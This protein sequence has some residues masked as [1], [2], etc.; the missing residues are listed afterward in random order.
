MK[1]IGVIG[2][3]MRHA[4]LARLLCES[5]YGV[6][7]YGIDN[8]G[9]LEFADRIRSTENIAEY[10]IVILPMPV[11]QD[12]ETINAPMYGSSIR[13]DAVMRNISPDAVVFGG[14][15]TPELVKK[16]KRLR[17]YDYLE[18]EDFA[19]KNA[20]AT[21]EGAIALAV[22]ET[23]FTLWNCRCLVVG[24]GRIGKTLVRLLSALGARVDA[25]AR[26]CCDRAW[27]NTVSCGAY[28]TADME[29]YIGN[30]D[31]I[32]NTVPNKLIDRTVLE[33]MKTGALVIDLA[34]KPGGA[35]VGLDK[36][37]ILSPSLTFIH[38]IYPPLLII[39]IPL[40][41]LFYSGFKIS[42]RQPTQLIVYLCRIYCISSVMSFSVFNI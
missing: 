30:Y 2:G 33:K 20:V 42:I 3:D 10:D 40:D 38:N 37:I 11:T 23:P 12:G 24:Y 31:L 41:S 15:L 9:E 7:V 35:D 34:S 8:D 5:G 29:R 4:I 17:F 18:R 1:R 25:A 19:V 32:F 6:G 22:T 26:R 28:D 36:E 14:K 21:A 16:Y 39:Q 13:L 27:I